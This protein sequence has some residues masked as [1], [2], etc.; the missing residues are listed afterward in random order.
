MISFAKL[1]SDLIDKSVYV[2]NNMLDISSS[3]ITIGCLPS[4]GIRSSV[5]HCCEK[6]FIVSGLS[7]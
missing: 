3:K 4:A 5:L 7:L 1:N 6:L 2:V